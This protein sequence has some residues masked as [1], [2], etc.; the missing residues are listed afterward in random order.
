[1][2]QLLYYTSKFVPLLNAGRQQ[3]LRTPPEGQPRS[4]RRAAGSMTS[5]GP[6]AVDVL[7]G[8]E[9][10]AVLREAPPQV[11]VTSQVAAHGQ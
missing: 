4:G 3:R 6:A 7:Q 2:S 1:M 9:A 5:P 11:Q 8:R 10:V